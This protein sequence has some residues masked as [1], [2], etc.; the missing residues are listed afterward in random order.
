MEGGSLRNHIN[1][2]DLREA[3]LCRT[4]AWNLSDLEPKTFRLS[5]APTVSQMKSVTIKESD[6][7]LFLC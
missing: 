1:P 7:H 3:H 5:E 6:F 2:E 4:A